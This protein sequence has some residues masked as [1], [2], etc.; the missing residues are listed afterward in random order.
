[1]EPNPVDKIRLSTAHPSGD[2]LETYALGLLP[3][4][5]LASF[6]THLFIC[7]ECQDALAAADDYVAAMKGALAEPIA[8]PVPSRWAAFVDSLRFSGPIPTF[9]AAVAALSLAA[10]MVQTYT[11]SLSAKEVEVTLRSVRGGLAS[12]ES[13]GPA[14][15]RL[16]LK[17]Q[18]EHLRVDESFHARIVNAGGKQIWDGTPE[19]THNSG[20]VL[21]VEQ[22]LGAGT[23][24]VRLYDPQQ[25]L[26]QEYGLN[27][28]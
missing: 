7:P 22:S 27:L 25:Q 16:T 23:Y 14:N 5:Q 2:M 26:L 28:D 18:S 15:S 13:M 19:F 21:H 4:K 11:P 17:I 20:Y 1:M 8:K 3:E 12:V 9:S 10:I 6:E 24:W